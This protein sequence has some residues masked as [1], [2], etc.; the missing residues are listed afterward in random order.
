MQQGRRQGLNCISTAQAAQV[1]FDFAF[2]QIGI[3]VNYPG[4][5]SFPLSRELTA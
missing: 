1:S 3:I 2:S 5:V 4:H